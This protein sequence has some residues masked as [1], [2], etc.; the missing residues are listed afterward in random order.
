M[1]TL[2]IYERKYSQYYLFPGTR[3]NWGS[4]LQQCCTFTWFGS[5]SHCTLSNEANLLNSVT[6][7]QWL[8][9][10]CSNVPVNT[11]EEEKAEQEEEEEEQKNAHLL[12][13]TENGNLYA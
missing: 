9:T 6:W 5:L 1:E 8:L 3:V 13:R 12:D 11:K 7:S 2:F 4:K 10:Y